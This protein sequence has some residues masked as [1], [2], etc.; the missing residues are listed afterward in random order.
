MRPRP[1]TRRRAVLGLLAALTSITVACGE[2]TEADGGLPRDATVF[3][4][5]YP[6]V[7]NLAPDLLRALR[8]AAAD[9]AA[10]G[11]TFTVNSGWR[12]PDHQDRLLREAVVKYGSRQAA[13]RW[14]ASAETSAHVSGDAV[15]LAPDAAKWLAVHGAAYG[16]CQIYANEPWHFELR[17]EAIHGG[18]VPMY[19]DPAHDPRMRR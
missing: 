10:D 1:V 11:V 16:L 15:D 14:V 12:S 3:D 19:P 2:S 17:P 13:A 6:G 5:R 4:D 8:Q 9:A 18:C 7:A